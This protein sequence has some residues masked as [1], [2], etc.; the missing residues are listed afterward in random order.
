MADFIK[1]LSVNDIPSGSMK[2]VMVGGK[3]IAVAHV[4]GEFFAI[5]DTCSHAQCSLGSEG[6]IDG[7]VVTCGCHGAQ[8]DVTNGKVMSLPAVVDVK[9]YSVKVEENDILIAI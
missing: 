6:F 5:D 9:S 4:D 2:T 1:A 8:F 3:P 7:S